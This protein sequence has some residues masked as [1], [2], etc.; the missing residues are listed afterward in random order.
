MRMKNMLTALT[1]T[2]MAAAATT[3][4]V[5]AVASSQ[6]IQSS[7]V[8]AQVVALM[9]EQQLDAFAMQ[10]PADPNRFTAMLLMP[11]VQMLMV[12]ATYPNPAE[13]QAQIAQKNYRDVYAALHQ[14]V[15]AASRFFLLD[16]GCDG[17]RA[18]SDVVDMLY[19]KGTIQTM[20]DGNWKK[21][22]LSQA[23][24]K[25]RLGQAEKRYAAAL[26]LFRDT[27]KASAAATRSSK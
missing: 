27:L 20:F 18:D 13:L 6:T 1:L 9:T 16:M 2:L 19:E 17:L 12:N 15:A 23:A 26:G 4:L 5:G 8:A 24:Y 22:G 7:S 21:Q 14:P 25:D 10:D 3:T 11:G